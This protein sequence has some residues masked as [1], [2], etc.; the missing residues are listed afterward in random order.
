MHGVYIDLDSKEA[1]QRTNYRS[2]TEKALK[3]I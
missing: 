2:V 3:G 1:I